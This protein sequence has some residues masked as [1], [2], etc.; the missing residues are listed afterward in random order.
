MRT[1]FKQRREHRKLNKVRSAIWSFFLKGSRHFQPVFGITHHSRLLKQQKLSWFCAKIIS[2]LFSRFSMLP[3]NFH[4]IRL[5]LIS[6]NIKTY[7]IKHNRVQE[8][9]FFYGRVLDKMFKVFVAGC[10][11]FYRK[12]TFFRHYGSVNSFKKV[13]RFRSSL[14]SVL[15]SRLIS[16]VWRGFF[17]SSMISA[18]NLII[19]GSVKV[20]G[21][22]VT[23]ANF[24]LKPGNLVKLVKGSWY[25]SQFNEEVG[26]LDLISF[27]VP[28]PHL[29]IRFALSYALFLYKPFDSELRFPFYPKIHFVRSF[30]FQ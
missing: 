3:N 25:T 14:I 11:V 10:E 18:Q 16:V 2:I 27:R 7:L 17:R 26:I 19:F 5:N 15:E 20:G 9:K 23:K 8:L 6:A 13:L 12:R 1:R 29:E 24:M 22:L 30:Y 28:S 21:Q 4:L